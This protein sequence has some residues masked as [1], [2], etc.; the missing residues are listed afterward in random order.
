MLVAAAAARLFD[1]FN[2]TCIDCCHVQGLL[3]EG[4]GNPH[5]YSGLENPVDRGT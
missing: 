1:P 4:D 2:Q 3:G 5:Q